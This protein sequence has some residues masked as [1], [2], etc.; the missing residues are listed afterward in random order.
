[1]RKAIEQGSPLPVCLSLFVQRAAL[2]TPTPFVRTLFF[3][4]SAARLFKMRTPAPKQIWVPFR[5]FRP[6]ARGVGRDGTPVGQACTADSG[7]NQ[8]KRS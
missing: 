3:P 1:M 6:V 7:H 2:K 8:K 5:R 4:E